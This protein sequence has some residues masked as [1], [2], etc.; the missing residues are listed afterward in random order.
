MTLTGAPHLSDSNTL[1][2]MAVE[3][4][5][6]QVYIKTLILALVPTM[7]ESFVNL[8]ML[9][10]KLNPYSLE[11]SL[12]QD[13]KVM[14]QTL[15]KQPAACSHPCPYCE[16]SKPRMLKAPNNILASHCVWYD[17]WIFA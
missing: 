12:S 5:E 1:M 11:Y 15:G 17:K 9:L 3:T 2:V 13:I 6:I 16:T 14:L 7:N 4:L 10:D 8:K